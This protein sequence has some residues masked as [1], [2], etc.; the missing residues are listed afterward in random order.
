MK[1]AILYYSSHHG[2]T[3][4]VVDAIAA[5]DSE[6]VLIDVTDAANAGADLT[7]YDRIG[8]ASGVY[9]GKPGKPIIKYAKQNM[10]VGKPSFFIMTSSM[11]KDGFLNQFR[12]LAAEKDSQVLGSFQCEGYDTFG[13]FK[14]VGGVS[15]GHPSE[16]DL[17]NA[18]EFYKGL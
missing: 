13:P 5:A 6:V 4:K 3:K 2:N 14:L 17:Q 16:E 8:L 9:G 7:S 10:P 11:C 12:E 15:K 1:T 18:V